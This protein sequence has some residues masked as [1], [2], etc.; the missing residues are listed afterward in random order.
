MILGE[1]R[2]RIDFMDGNRYALAATEGVT[3]AHVAKVTND[4]INNPKKRSELDSG[5]Y[6]TA[7]IDHSKRLGINVWKEPK[8]S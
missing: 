6:L 1:R 3:D 4:I 7:V 8:C 2:V 5:V